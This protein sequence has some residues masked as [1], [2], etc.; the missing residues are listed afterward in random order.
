MLKSFFDNL[1][2]TADTEDKRWISF[3]KV[4]IEFII[5][6]F[7]TKNLN[8]RFLRTSYSSI[9]PFHFIKIITGSKVFS[10]IKSVSIRVIEAH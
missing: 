10:V 9:L 8:F 4:K 2:V 6:G 1:H 7:K 3:M 5:R